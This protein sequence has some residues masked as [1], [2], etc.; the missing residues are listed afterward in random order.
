MFS[1]LCGNGREETQTECLKT[2]K[3]VT[4]CSSIY[5][6]ILRDAKFVQTSDL[7]KQ[8][9]NIRDLNFLVRTTSFPTKVNCLHFSLLN[10]RHL[11]PTYYPSV[12]E[13]FFVSQDLCCSHARWGIY[14]FFPVHK[15]T[16][17][18][19][20]IL[21]LLLWTLFTWMSCFQLMLINERAVPYKTLI[22]SSMES[23]HI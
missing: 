9:S 13:K 16:F 7:E 22:F 6:L 11:Y 5:C 19:L 23:F 4:G 14:S 1:C 15:H 20:P 10:L 21:N 18:Y 12:Q 17:S 3:V 2:C 8:S